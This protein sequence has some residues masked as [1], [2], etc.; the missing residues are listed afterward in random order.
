[1]PTQASVSSAWLREAS[2]DLQQTNANVFGRERVSKRKRRSQKRGGLTP[3]EGGG[4]EEGNKIKMGHNGNQSTSAKQQPYS[5]TTD[6]TGGAHTGSGASEK[7]I[8]SFLLFDG[9]WACNG[10]GSAASKACD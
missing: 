6:A 1:M 8:S 7:F 10:S 4:M 9:A 5:K 2:S 3:R